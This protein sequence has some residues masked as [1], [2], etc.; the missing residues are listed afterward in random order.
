MVSPWF[1][2]GLPWFPRM[3]PLTLRPWVSFKLRICSVSSK[4]PAELES[5]SD[6]SATP[7][8]RADISEEAALSS[9]DVGRRYHVV[10]SFDPGMPTRKVQQ[11]H[12]WP[13][14]ALMSDAQ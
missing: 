14:T 9:A 12:E 11:T 7:L 1:P 13:Q 10:A 2:H 4:F 3:F 5:T 8:G 6:A